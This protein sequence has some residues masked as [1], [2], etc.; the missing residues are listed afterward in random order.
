MRRATRPGWEE[1]MNSGYSNGRGRTFRAARFFAVFLGLVTLSFV[2]GIPFTSPLNPQPGTNPAHASSTRSLSATSLI[3]DKSRLVSS[4]P[5]VDASGEYLAYM[6]SP[7][8][9]YVIYTVPQDAEYA[10]ITAI[11]TWTTDWYQAQQELTKSDAFLVEVPFNGGHDCDHLWRHPENHQVALNMV[12]MDQSWTVTGSL[13]VGPGKSV[14][15]AGSDCYFPDNFYA[16]ERVQW[17]VEVV[18]QVDFHVEITGPGGD[19]YHITPAGFS[20]DTIK[21]TVTSHQT[22]QPLSD[23]QVEFGSS[24]APLS[25][26]HL[27]T[28]EP[29]GTRPAGEWSTSLN[30]PSPPV[31]TTSLNTDAQ[32]R[33]QV[34]YRPGQAKSGCPFED[35]STGRICGIAGLYSVWVRPKDVPVDEEWKATI[36]ARVPGLVQLTGGANYV[37]WRK[38]EH[39]PGPDPHPGSYYSTAATIRQVPSLGNV[40]QQK[41]EQHNQQLQACGVQP[42][43]VVPLSVNDMST[44]WGGLFDYQAKKPWSPGHLT[45]GTG[46]GVDF[47][48]KYANGQPWEGRRPVCGGG[49]APVST[50]LFGTL[51]A[52]GESLGGQWDQTDLGNGLLHLRFNQNGLAQPKGRSAVTAG[53]DLGVAVLPE[54]YLSDLLTVAGRPLTLT[55]GVDNINGDSA[56]SNSILTATLPAGTSYL[57]ASPPPA[58]FGSGGEP[59]WDLGLLQ[60][61]EL[62]ETFLVTTQVSSSVAAGTVLTFTSDVSTSDPETVL[63]N[64]EAEWVTEVRAPGADIVVDS[65]IDSAPMLA[66]QPVTFTMQL[67]NM[68]NAVASASVLSLTLPMS[69]TLASSTPFTSTYAGGVATWNLGDLNPGDEQWVT[70]TL[71]LDPSLISWVQPDPQQPPG[72]LLQYLI[73]GHTTS[74]E[75]YPSSDSQTISAPVQRMGSDVSVGV[76]LDDRLTVGQDITVTI[77]YGNFGN[78]VAPSSTLTMSL[79]SGLTYIVAQPTPSRILTSTN[80]GGGMYVWDL[81]SLDVGSSGQIQAQVHVSSIPVGGGEILGEIHTTGQD[82]FAGNDSYHASYLA[83]PLLVGHVTWQGRPAQ[84]N[85]L[86]QLPVSLTLRLGAAQPAYPPITTDSSGFF[87]ASVT[88]SI[89]GTYEW[90]VKNPK[91][92]ANSGSVT[93]ATTPITNFE[94][95]LMRAGDANNDNR[96]NGQDFTILK[97]TFGQACGN[98]GY[99][100][101][102]DFTGDCR[103]NGQDFNLLKLNFGSAGLVLPTYTPTPTST[104]TPTYPPSPTVTNT[105]TG[106]PPTY[107]P[108]RTITPTYTYTPTGTPPTYTPTRTPTHTATRTPT[109]TRTPTGTPPTAT[110]TQSA[111]VTATP[112]ITPTALPQECLAYVYT[113][114][115]AT[116]VPGTLDTGNHCDDC[117]TSINLPFPFGL[118]GQYFTTGNVLSNGSLQFQGIDPSYYVYCPPSGYSQYDAYALG[119]DLVTSSEYGPCPGCGIFTSVSGSAP[120]RIFNIEWRAVYFA[121]GTP[122]NFEIRLYEG[123][124][125][126]DYVYSN[127]VFYPSS[128][129]ALSKDYYTYMCYP[130][131]VSQGL[132]IIWTLPPCG[133]VTPTPTSTRTLTPTITPAP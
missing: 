81:G 92:L 113:T 47:N 111:T 91:Y 54:D 2:G 95:G 79:W 10:I 46:I 16:H 115:Q 50:W 42:W 58:R 22:G 45:H 85:P 71:L 33:I 130:G 8:Y 96:I 77:P 83:V 60:A 80:Y 59:V 97:S 87:T 72:N 126:L 39:Q 107:T 37:R 124:N 86:Q 129:V 23:Y 78:H 11:G 66:G 14:A 70:A 131:V 61:G 29:D 52:A 105:P 9:S 13:T 116:I 69:V 3:G 112:T 121:Y 25:G 118:Y 5:D 28:G 101:R 32:G 109:P 31:S 12:N 75:I 62:P 18:R 102:A 64:N 104:Q 48:Q 90:I 98:P 21:V 89:T 84:P 40:F 120:N 76:N 30:W 117:A 24:V 44:G 26:F 100:D 34:Y 110:P 15:I 114:A 93:L 106:T 63:D 17:S 6:A 65:T 56:A 122:V 123:Q 49:T 128:V 35:L 36:S 119:D 133:S 51:K 82:Y 99:D 4:S 127:S 125:R 67:S 19:P 38:E 55:V 57:S 53:P 132:S 43:P 68:G 94:M 41:Q 73:S 7:G 1:Q 74:P 27:H 20:M 103:V 108:T 88:S